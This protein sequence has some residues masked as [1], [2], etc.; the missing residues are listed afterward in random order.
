MEW[1]HFPAKESGIV[2]QPS[3]ATVR[4]VLARSRV[5]AGH[6][7][8][9][10]PS[11]AAGL[12]ERFAEAWPAVGAKHREQAAD[13]IRF[14]RAQRERWQRTALAVSCSYADHR[15]RLKTFANPHGWKAS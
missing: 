13:S 3:P 2:G 8:A 11:A 1:R 9:A 7:Q 12:S 5:L 10:L 14:L 15:A 4:F 6:S